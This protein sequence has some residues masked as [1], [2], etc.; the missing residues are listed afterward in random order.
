M[1]SF[2]DPAQAFA[3]GFIERNDR[4]FITLNDS[5]FYFG[6]LGMQETRS[7]GLM[8]AILERHGF[9]VRR[10]ISGFATSFLATYGG[11][12][13][14]IAIHTE[15]DANPSNSQMPGVA[16][17]TEIVAGAPGHCEGHNTNAAVMIASALAIRYAMEKFDLPGTLR[18]FG[19]SAEEQ[20][21]SRPYFVRD[22]L[23]DDVDLA[24][25]DH[26]LDRFGTDYGVIQSAAISAEFT[27]H[28]EAAH[29]AVSPWKGRDALD[30]LMLMDAGIAQYREHMKPTM[31]AH[32]VITHGGE[33][34]NV[35][36]SK[37][38][39]WWYFRDP[40]AEGAGVLFERARK[41]AQG[42]ALMAD[43]EL[44]VDVRA[45][46]RLNQTIAEVIQRNVERVGMPS[47][48]EQEDAFAR[49]LQKQAGAPEIGLRTSADSL[50]GPAVQIAASN[51]C[52]DVSWKVPMGRIW[53]P[54]NVPHLPFHHWTAGAP[55]ATSIAH[56][57]GLAGAK[58]LAASA[59]EF[60]QD[61]TL[62]AETKASFGRELAGTVY[63]PLL[64]ED[65]R[66]PAHLNL[67]L[68][69]KF[70]PQMEAHYLRDEPV[71]A[72]P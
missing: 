67:A 35:I 5:I 15:Y 56:K 66:A 12:A 60:F 41:I 3:A 30:A 36:P 64:P 17:R 22:G 29:A 33:Q 48:T 39:C 69:E 43:C 6:E 16:E 26:V 42:A 44:A 31:T 70:R 27:F 63:R 40:T 49:S 25:H 21:L 61:N 51:D 34:P 52:G 20:L 58:A 4:A 19:A 62:V 37:A 50:Q 45:A 7:A 10:G 9:S 18:I 11:G 2:S 53:F 54:G 32:R 65:Q 46:V 13:P 47:W 68:M 24:F 57:G 23:F 59:I 38:A 14:V 55:L 72:T 1:S 8:T 71:F 28:G